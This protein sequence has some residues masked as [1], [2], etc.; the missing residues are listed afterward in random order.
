LPLL[1]PELLEPELSLD[2][3]LLPEL[4]PVPPE[5]ELLFV[6]LDDEEEPREDPLPLPLAEPLPLNDPPLLEL[7]EE[8]GV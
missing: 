3:E 7:P 2:P 1:A 8:E 5:L 4:D 6:L